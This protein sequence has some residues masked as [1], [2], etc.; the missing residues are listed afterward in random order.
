M[1]R[2][3]KKI[4][5]LFGAGA[6][7]A[8][9]LN[10]DPD[11]DT[12]NEGLLISH[13][14]ERVMLRARL[15]G[16]YFEG[17]ELVSGTGGSLNIELLITLIENSRIKN[18]AEKTHILKELIRR[19]IASA[20]PASRTRRFCLHKG[21]LELHRH[22]KTQAKEELLGL[23]T[24]NYERVLDLAYQTVISNEINYSLSRD[25]DLAGANNI[26]LLKLH[27]S[28]SWTNQQ[29]LGKRREIEIIPLGLSKSYLHPP[30][31]FIWNRA[32]DILAKCDLLRIIGCSLSPNDVHLIDLLFKAQLERQRP[33]ELQI[34]NS[35]DAADMIKSNY[36]FFREIK[37]IEDLG[38][39]SV[40]VTG[41]TNPF[42]TWLEYTA[43]KILS[44]REI[45]NL[46]HLRNSMI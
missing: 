23:I 16:D 18:W 44:G 45:A 42:K 11:L 31:G 32:L 3:P 15:N 41:P 14:S 13:L 25:M 35:N 29:V 27:G 26:P 8:E 4:A 6:T 46:R 40:P 5:Y 19:E 36:G 38:V 33:F 17:L 34:I 37:S 21:L 12:K 2:G 39:P 7:H 24:L 10:L 30:Y 1:E 22:A 43:K 28:F 9:L 20:L